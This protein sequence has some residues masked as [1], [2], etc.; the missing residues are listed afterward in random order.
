VLVDGD[1]PAFVLH[2]RAAAPSAASASA[3]R[4]RSQMLFVAGM[5]G[6]P[7][8]YV[9]S[10]AAPAAA[11]GDVVMVQGDVSC[12]GDGALRRWSNDLEAMGR[13]IEAAFRAS[14]LGEPRDVVV[15]GYSQGAERVERLAARWPERYAS[16][17][18]LAGPTLPSPHNL[19]KAHG[20]VLMAGT[21]ETQANMRSAVGPLRRAGVPSAFFELPAGRHGNLGATPSESMT[22]ALDFLG[23]SENV[24]RALAVPSHGEPG[25]R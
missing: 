9:Q 1:L 12:G 10:F 14:G 4:A 18:L 19:A 15:I 23:E 13:R 11:R 25:E 3:P 5:C 16:A 8:G 22:K 20:I 7:V 2:H 21:Y 17:I 6:H 24:N